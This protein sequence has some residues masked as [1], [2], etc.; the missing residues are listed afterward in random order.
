VGQPQPSHDD[1]IRVSILVSTANILRV[2]KM[3]SATAVEYI[4]TKVLYSSAAGK[5]AQTLID[6]TIVDVDDQCIFSGLPEI[7]ADRFPFEFAR[8]P[9]ASDELKVTYKFKCNTE[10]GPNGTSVLPRLLVNRTC[11]S[12]GIFG[13]FQQ[14]GRDTTVP[15]KP[16][17]LKKTFYLTL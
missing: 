4:C 10:K 11:L 15:K 2:K 13:Q 1:S 8:I 17:K 7:L 16:P 5:P 14:W 9:V 6:Y 3:A 12:F